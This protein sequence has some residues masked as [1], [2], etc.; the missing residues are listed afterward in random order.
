MKAIH[1][2]EEKAEKA[3]EHVDLAH[4][5]L[6][7]FEGKGGFV[8]LP[9]GSVDN[10]ITAEE[11][12]HGEGYRQGQSDA[13]CADPLPQERQYRY[14][15]TAGPRSHSDGRD[16]LVGTEHTRAYS[17]TS[18]STSTSDRDRSC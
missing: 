6:Q 10:H 13:R 8:L 18:A 17:D 14:Q 12:E 2:A 15:H 7:V 1:H 3:G 9:P 5:D 11:Y 16:S 4:V